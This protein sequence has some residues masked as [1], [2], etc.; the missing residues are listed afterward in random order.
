MDIY[1]YLFVNN[2]Y[3]YISYMLYYIHNIYYILTAFIIWGFFGGDRIT[4]LMERYFSILFFSIL[5][6]CIG[7]LCFLA[8]LHFVF[9]IIFLTEG[10]ERPSGED[11]P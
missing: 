10:F 1:L 8:C 3:I 5:F 7:L 9:I 4:S 11:S 6:C 2:P